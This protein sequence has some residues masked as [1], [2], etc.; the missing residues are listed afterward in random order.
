MVV[1]WRVEASLVTGSMRDLGRN[2]VVWAEEED[3]MM[4][5]RR[6]MK[7]MKWYGEAIYC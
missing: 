2:D 1:Y 5:K 3:I 4:G 7:S 6:E